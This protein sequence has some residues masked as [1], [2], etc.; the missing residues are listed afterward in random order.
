MEETFEYL[1][2][3]RRTERRVAM[4]TLVATKGTT[5]RKE[6]AKMWVGEGGRILGSVTIGGCVA[7]RVV[8][9]SEDVLASATPRLLSMQLGDEDAWDLGLSCGGTVDVLIEPIDLQPG[10]GGVGRG[11]GSALLDA[12]ETIRQEVVQGRHAVA[13][14][15]LNG[16]SARLVV[17]EDG[18]I[19]GTLG[20]RALDDE[21]RARALES[22]QQGRS[23]TLTLGRQ[24]SE[25]L[26]AFFEL[27]GPPSTLLVFGAGHVAMPLVQFAKILGWKVVVVDGRERFATRDRFPDANEIRIGML[28]EIA[29][30]FTYTPSTFVVLVAH[31]YKYDIPVLRTVLATDAAYIGLLGSRKRGRAILEFLAEE[32]ISPE[33]LERV[34]VPVGLDIGAQT[35]AEIALSVL[36]EAIAVRTGRPGTSL[37]TRRGVGGAP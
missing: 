30:Q 11:R 20:N 3:L 21:A 26:D 23:G 27:H 22:I 15:P 16:R 5:P 32:G 9:E 25:S 7:G 37:R 34:H 31:D 14:T 29:E 28:S 35:A 33:V 4:A 24:S 36:A 12:Y 6:G 18:S 8:A 1:E 10:G 19:A 17:R 13:V 2:Q